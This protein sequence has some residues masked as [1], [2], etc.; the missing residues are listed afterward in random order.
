MS[1]P[2]RPALSPAQEEHPP[3]RR[4]LLDDVERE[5]REHGHPYVAVDEAKKALFSNLRLKSFHFVV[6]DKERD[7]WL[8]WCGAPATAV[9]QNMAE[10]AQVFGEG[11]QVVY[12]VRRKGGISY[13]TTAGARLT[14]T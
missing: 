4:S 9:R 7:N 5:L 13:R 12:A 2:S 11:Y 8:L 10:W 6:Y 14:L 3:R 1:A